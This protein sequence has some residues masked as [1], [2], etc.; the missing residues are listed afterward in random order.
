MKLVLHIFNSSQLST[1]HM[2]KKF[3]TTYWWT[4]LFLKRTAKIKGKSDLY[5]YY[6]EAYASYFFVLLEWELKWI[7]HVRIVI[8]DHMIQ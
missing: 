1:E 5:L 8:F 2:I 4:T 6:E 7:P 3:F